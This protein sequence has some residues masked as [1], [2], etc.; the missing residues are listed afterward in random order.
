[1]KVSEIIKRSLR[2][3]LGLLVFTFGDYI[4]IN[5]NIGLPSW[6]CLSVGLA[7][8]TGLTVG[9]A[10]LIIS[11]VLLVIDLIL[12]ERIGLGTVLDAVLCG[13]FLDVYKLFDISNK[14]GSIVK[15]LLMLTAA[16][17][18]M[19]I[20]Q[21]IYM[22]AGICCGPRDA[23]LVGVGKRLKR[24]PIG[25]VQVILFVVILL[26]GYLL[27]GKVGIGTIYGTFGMGVIMQIVFR[28]VRFEPRNVKH[29]DFIKMFKK[30]KKSAVSDRP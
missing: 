24:L 13:T 16:M 10:T 14:S 19:A 30:E 2:A 15:G 12:G 27:G 29:V 4:L 3:A 8:K 22:K 25:A 23:L 1:M 21:F 20:G 18:L 17:T 5:S 6:D 11:F 7:S 28:I 9:R 26:A